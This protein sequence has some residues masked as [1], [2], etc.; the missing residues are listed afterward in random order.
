MCQKKDTPP[1]NFRDVHAMQQILY[2]FGPLMLA[3]GSFR[4]LLTLSRTGGVFPSRT[5][6]TASEGPAKHILCIS[7]KK[8][9]SISKIDG[10]YRNF[11]QPSQFFLKFLDFFFQT[12]HGHSSV[13]SQD[14]EL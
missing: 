14:T 5:F 6:L 7:K 3:D 1:L 4:E 2:D 9:D 8:F 13:I 12:Y 10:S 11:C